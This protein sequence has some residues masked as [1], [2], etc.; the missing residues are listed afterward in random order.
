MQ[1]ETKQLLFAVMTTAFSTPLTLFFVYMWDI[2][3]AAWAMGLNSAIL[4]FTKELY[5]RKW[6]QKRRAFHEAT[7]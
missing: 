3:G 1:K 7:D 2:A 5:L 6:L 4:Y